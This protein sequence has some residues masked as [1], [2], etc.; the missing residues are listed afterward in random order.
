[1]SLLFAGTPWRDPFQGDKERALGLELSPLCDR[2][3]TPIAASQKNFIGFIVKPL[4][5]SWVTFLDCPAADLCSA[6]LE[7]SKP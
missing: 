3:A 4:F 7:V 5:K 6:N 1:M 2:Y